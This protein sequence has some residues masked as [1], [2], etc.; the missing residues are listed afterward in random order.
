MRSLAYIA[1]FVLVVVASSGISFIGYHYLSLANA[2]REANFRHLD[3][4]Y[5]SI[6][7]AGQNPILKPNDFAKLEEN[8]GVALAETEWCLENLGFVDRALFEFMGVGNAIQICVDG[9]V[10]GAQALN[11]LEELK[12]SQSQSMTASFILHNELMI[13]LERLLDLSLAFPPLL[14]VVQGDL[15]RFVRTGTTVVSLLLI[16]MS[17]AVAKQIIAVQQ[18][19]KK[20]SITDPLTGLM[21]RRGLD[22]VVFE[23]STEQEIILARIDLDRFKRVNDVLGHDAGDFVLTHVAGLMRRYTRDEDVLAR[24]GGDEF[25]ILFASDTS[26]ENAQLVVLRMLASVT[27]P[28]QYRDKLCIYG[29]SFGL[30]STE[31]AGPSMSNLLSAADKALYQV[32]RSGRGAVAIYSEEMHEEAKQERALAERFR[33]ALEGGE[34]VP[35]FQSQHLAKDW[36]LSGV[37]VLARWEHPELGTLCPVQFLDI[38]RQLG[39]EA[40]LDKRLFQDTIRFV[41]E[42]DAKGLRLPRVSFNVSLGRI[43]DPS[44]L[45]DVATLIPHER[46]RFAF[47]ILESVSYEEAADVLKL[48]IDGIRELGFQIDVD[49][50][51]SGHASINGVVNIQPDALKIDR[52]IIA[53]IEVNE[54]SL[55]MVESIIELANALNLEVI[56]EG[57]DSAEKAR[58]LRERGCHSLQGYHFSKPMPGRDLQAFLKDTTRVQIAG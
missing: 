2:Y 38:A 56:A 53:P 52:G 11:T 20:Q 34:I 31:L 46:S 57:V 48:A 43:T 17:A 54:Q 44:F 24:V 28:V 12:S 51:G 19:V 6:D 21:N 58:L 10:S 33:S 1:F 13:E 32:K 9:L 22:D 30:A 50:F 4:V 8:I 27:E 49:D 47:E 15:E 40:D 3:V 25:V 18:R 29:A 35:F 14:N 55:R 45:N 41:A 7:I 16:L 5:Q 36:S 42:L 37:E 39:M 26:L 23:Q